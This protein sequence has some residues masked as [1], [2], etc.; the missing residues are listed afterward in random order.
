MIPMRASRLAVLF[1]LLL[2]SLMSPAQAARPEH[3]LS[4]FATTMAIIETSALRCIA[5][6]LYLAESAQQQAQGLM[7]IERLDEY[8]GM[9]FRYREPAT[10]TM[11]MKNTYI[12]LDM[13]FVRQDGR[14]A[15]I[16]SHTKP[17]S[18]ARIA[19]PEPVTTVIE[20]N[21]GFGERHAFETGDRLLAVN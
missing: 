1:G 12:S 21:A 5:V 18:T 14:V 16:A 19:S 13:V 2:I 9:L 15:G 20:F 4:G 7:R 11:W 17:M 6:K 8:E 10:I 3:L